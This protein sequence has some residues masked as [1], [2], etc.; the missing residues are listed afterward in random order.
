MENNEKKKVGY[1][2]IVG[3]PNVG[4]STLLNRFVRTKLSIVSPK[5]QTTI[6]NVIG[7]YTKNNVQMIFL[8]TPGIIKPKNIVFKFL[9]KNIIDAVQDADVVVIMVE[10][11]FS[12]DDDFKEF[13][14]HVKE[15]AKI[16][17]INKIDTV[18]IKKELLPKIDEFAKLGFDKVF[19]ISATSGDGVD[20]LEKAIAELLPE[21]EFLYP[22][23]QISS[24]SERFFVSEIIREAVFD[25]YG[26][27]IPYSVY[28][29]IEEFREQPDQKKDYIRAT[30]YVERDSQKGIMIGKGGK[31][32]KKLGIEA[33]QRIENFLQRPIYLEL[34]V[35]VY[36]NWRKNE[37]F[38]RNVFKRP[39]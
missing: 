32:I 37:M 6:H 39:A 26:E 16:L 23:E 36:K 15:K 33:R 10:P 17:V 12:P 11:D 22:P 8:D 9:W 38:V 3:P 19:L 4:K 20:D 13:L 5:P 27:E 29:E 18:K 2:A 28:V 1:V 30:I 25:L 34:N 35:K 31:A 7:I 21:G 14:K 24:H